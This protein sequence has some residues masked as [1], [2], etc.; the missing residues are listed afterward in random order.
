MDGLPRP[1]IKK[2]VTST[3]RSEEAMTSL[4]CSRNR[5]PANNGNPRLCGCTKPTAQIA[6][7]TAQIAKYV[8]WV[9]A[10]KDNLE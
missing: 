5:D 4:M 3:V 9:D 2:A 1:K 10:V 7:P 8:N 6:K